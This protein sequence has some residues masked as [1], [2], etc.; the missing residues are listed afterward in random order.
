MGRATFFAGG[1]VLSL[2]AT[3]FAAEPAQAERRRADP[4]KTAQPS[5]EEI[6]V[7]LSS[8]NGDEVRTAIE[9]AAGL[10][11]P[12]VIPMIGERVRAGLPPDL[13]DAAIDSLVLLGDPAVADVFVELATHRRPSVRLRAVQA[14]VAMRGKS[15]ER[16]LTNAL[17][18]SSPAVREAAAEGL[19]EMGAK[20]TLD[21][22]FKA[23]DRGVLLAGK[24]IGQ[25]ANDAALPRILA[26]LGRVPMPSLTP[27]FDALLSRRDISEATKLQ[28]VVQLQELGTAEARG[29]LEGLGTR[30][31]PDAPA[32]LRRAI[33]DAVVRIAP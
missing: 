28:L 1:A 22:L 32:R 10:G 25:L 13:L 11:S 16:V 31:P 21:T 12:D 23:F 17:G 9:A 2:A 19:G 20:A 5:L 7:M 4:A 30:L 33:E 29:Y 18:D 15:A 14:L 27:M 3:L 6:A 8:S 26:Y 24:A